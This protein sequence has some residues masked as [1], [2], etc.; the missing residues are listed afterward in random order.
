MLRV[1]PI[2]GPSG[3][4]FGVS[5]RAMSSLP[6][7][8]PLLTSVALLAACGEQ[9][10]TTPPELPP[11]VGAL[12]LPLSFRNDAPAPSD[13]LR[14]EA[15]MTEL[16]LDG[17]P[18]YTGLTRGTVPET[19]RSAEGGLTQLLAR[20]RAAP[21]R[22]RAA[23]TLLGTVPYATVVRVIETLNAAGYREY[24]FAVHPPGSSPTTIGWLGLSSPQIAPAQGPYAFPGGA[25]P[26]SDFT[27]HWADMY[28][29]CRGGRYIDCDGA[30][31]EPAQ[32]GD[33]QIVLWSRGQGMQ[34]R[35]NQ[36]NAP[37]AATARPA[38]VQMIEGVPAP[39]AAAPV[40]EG[41]P[42]DTSGVFT[43]RAEDATNLAAG[44]G[45]T[46]VASSGISATARPVC[47][48]TPCAAIVEA[49]PETPI[50]RVLSFVG[51]AFP[52][53]SA[54]PTLAFR[55]PE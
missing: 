3:A 46:Q 29:A 37:A 25:R 33:L 49:D 11:L 41:P 12:E 30:P 40:E 38:A 50:M 22:S 26:W 47:G 28:D 4:R 16:R 36:I 15:S 34:M 19:E 45:G 31:S 18:V 5:S 23:L 1:E 52:N 44:P 35:F 21:A 20:V 9:A 2:A 43:F 53:G 54:P 10:P 39:R 24:A 6:R 8:V 7:L 51:A 17:Q 32:G 14:I 42:P 27:A 13:A 48:A 55:A